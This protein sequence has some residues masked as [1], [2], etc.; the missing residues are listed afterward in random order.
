MN[1]EI[2]ITAPNEQAAY[3][4]VK[5]L[6]SL[7]VAGSI[8]LYSSRVIEKSKD[9]AVTIESTRGGAAS[10]G[11]ALGLST[12]ML[13]GLLGG[14]VGV[15]VGGTVGGVAGFAGDTAY[16]GFTGDF[17]KSVSDRLQPGSVAVVASVWEDWSGPIDIEVAKVGGTVSRQMT[18]DL[19]AA[20]LDADTRA[21]QEDE[22]RM[23]AEIE[24]STGEIKAKLEAK[25]TELRARNDRHRERLAQRANELEQTLEARLESIK[26]KVGDSKAEAKKRHEEH[27][28]KLSH[29]MDQQ[30]AAFR[31]LFAS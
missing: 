10:W 2:V 15:A 13:I 12:G 20:Q 24:A 7:D 26:Q 14:P 16:S 9:G 5:A 3:E 4:V 27:M 29:F 6:R 11:T 30:K 23:D 8:E 25:R 17:I 21:L 28:E 1:K 19:V 22:A 31:Q 18:D